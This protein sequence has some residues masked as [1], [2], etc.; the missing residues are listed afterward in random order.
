MKALIFDLD[1]TLL[2]SVYAHVLAFQAAFAE[3][4]RP[5]GG[6]QIHRLIGMSGAQL[7]QT[8]A[9]ENRQKISEEEIHQLD[10]RHGELFHQ[11]L[12]HPVPLPGAVELLRLLR[13]RKILHGIATSSTHADTE[14]ALAA[15]GLGRETVVVERGDVAHTKPEPDPFVECQK[16]LGVPAQEC[17]AIGDAVWDLLA[18]RRAGMLG[19]GLLTGGNG[20]GELFKAGPYRVFQDVQEFQEHLDELGLSPSGKHAHPP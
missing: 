2:D 10:R 14:K 3:A 20:A 17:Y 8:V 9:R 1:G 5:V 11:F 13:R 16:R 12:P 19:I 6:W 18:A 4:E 15:L 7:V